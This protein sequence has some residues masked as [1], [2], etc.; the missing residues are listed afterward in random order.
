[1]SITSAML[2]LHIYLSPIMPGRLAAMLQ[3]R[4]QRAIDILEDKQPPPAYLDIP[5]IYRPQVL[6]VLNQ[7]QH[8]ASARLS[9]SKLRREIVLQRH[10]EKVKWDLHHSTS[11]GPRPETAPEWKTEK[12]FYEQTGVLA[13][14][15]P[16]DPAYGDDI[17]SAFEASS[18]R[19]I[20]RKDAVAK[21]V[22]ADWA[23]NVTM[24]DLDWVEALNNMD[25]HDIDVA[26]DPWQFGAALREF[27][28]AKS[29]A[30][31][32]ELVAMWF[33]FLAECIGQLQN[34]MKIE[35]C[36]GS[37]TTVL[38]QIRCG[39]IGRRQQSNASCDPDTAQGNDA[40]ISEGEE[41]PRVYDRIHL[42]NIPDY[43]GGTLAWFLYALPL[44]HAGDGSYITSTCLRNPPRFKTE[45]HFH[46][47]YVSLSAPSDL[48]KVFRVRSSGSCD[49]E[50]D[51]MASSVLGMSQVMN[52]KCSMT[53]LRQE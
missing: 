32:Y 6:R 20:E 4:V 43:I 52:S 23:S 28:P 10:S 48:A 38:E 25:A 15:K 40:T 41:Y 13:V 3:A 45:A 19:K 46:N 18:A 8:D 30:G 9:V 21:K 14:P 24:I 11:M 49:P 26:N 29:G 16:H 50:L 44:T 35:M 1:M 39:A 17:R 42:S 12:Q 33:N 34:S 22:E 7:W 2:L 51:K 27:I 36:L 5:H 47:E 37:I 31:L 53:T